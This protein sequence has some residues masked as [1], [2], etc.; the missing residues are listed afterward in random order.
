MSKPNYDHK[1]EY[2]RDDDIRA[3]LRSSAIATAE[4]ISEPRRLE[5]LEAR[6]QVLLSRLPEG[7]SLEHCARDYPHLVNRIA[8]AWHDEQL[9]SRY[10]DGLLVND[11][12]GRAG[13]SFEVL[14][15]LT[16][17]REARKRQLTGRRS[18]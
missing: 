12:G 4:P 7:A 13:F 10:L 3:P 15:E 5:P 16:D 2:L 18:D 1:N 8:A 17:L 11:R 9:L 6:A 14:V